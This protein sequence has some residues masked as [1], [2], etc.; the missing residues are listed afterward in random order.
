MDTGTGKSYIIMTNRPKD[1]SLAVTERIRAFL[2]KRGA[3]VSVFADNE[4][5]SR[6]GLAEE[7]GKMADGPA[8]PGK[9]TD[10]DGPAEP[11][12]PADADR[13]APHAAASCMIVLG[14]DGTMLKAA[15]ETAASRRPASR[16]EPGNRGLP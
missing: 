9:R 14:G 10:T 4:D 5:A 2:E 11:G 3:R 13:T 12:K 6:L 8:E 1:P 15:R 16:R 7:P